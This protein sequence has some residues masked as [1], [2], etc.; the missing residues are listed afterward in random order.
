ML[1]HRAVN[2]VGIPILFAVHF[3]VL[4]ACLFVGSS[5][6]AGWSVLAEVSRM[7]AHVSRTDFE[8]V[9]DDEPHASRRK[10]ILS[11][12]MP[13]LD[14]EH[15]SCGVRRSIGRVRG[16]LIRSA[17]ALPPTSHVQPFRN[18]V[19]CISSAYLPH[20]FPRSSQKSGAEP[21]PK[22]FT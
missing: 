13:F 18:L 6:L 19:P 8:W 20:T 12:W 10:V 1:R 21:W 16:V 4:F 15:L 7:G 17:P 14:H 2:I 5:V 9:H 11:E 3:L 22:A